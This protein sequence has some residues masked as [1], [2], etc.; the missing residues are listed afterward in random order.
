MLFE[1]NLQKQALLEARGTWYIAYRLGKVQA[2]MTTENPRKKTCPPPPRYLRSPPVVVADGVA[3]GY[4]RAH[5]QQASRQAP[6]SAAAALV[7]LP[8]VAESAAVASL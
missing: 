3:E 8:S 5:S 6:G 2:G 1:S 4:L 7:V